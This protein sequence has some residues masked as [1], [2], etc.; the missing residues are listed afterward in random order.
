MRLLERFFI[1]FR[2]IY[3]KYLIYSANPYT[4]PSIYRR[5][6]GVKIGEECV[7][8]GKRISFGSEPYLIEIGNKVRITAD[9]KFETHDGGVGIFRDEYPGINVFGKIKIGDNSFIGHGSIIMSGVSIGKN[10]VIGA[11]SIVTKNIPSNSLA[12]GIPAKVIKSI[13]EYKESCLKKAFFIKNSDTVKRKKE[14]LSY[15]E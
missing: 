14:I 12:V 3:I 5:Y 11:G 9:V 2:H 1:L 15:F 6:Y 13:E 10:V 8:T 7:F 4:L